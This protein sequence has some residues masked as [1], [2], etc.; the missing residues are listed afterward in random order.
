MIK[1]TFEL[2]REPFDRAN[3]NRDLAIDRDSS[4]AAVKARFQ[5]LA[6]IIVSIVSVP[7]LFLAGLF[8]LL[9]GDCKPLNI[10]IAILTQLFIII[11][12]SLL[13][14]IFPMSW[15]RNID[16]SLAKCTR[17]RAIENH[18][19]DCLPYLQNRLTRLNAA[20]NATIEI[21]DLQAAIAQKNKNLKAQALTQTLSEIRADI[22]AA[23]RGSIAQSDLYEMFKKKEEHLAIESRKTVA[24][25]TQAFLAAHNGSISSQN[26]PI[27]TLDKLNQALTDRTINTNGLIFQNFIDT[28]VIKRGNGPETAQTLQGLLATAQLLLAEP[29]AGKHPA[30]IAAA[31]PLNAADIQEAATPLGQLVLTATIVKKHTSQQL[32]ALLPPAD[33]ATAIVQKQGEISQ[34]A[35]CET[36]EKIANLKATHRNNP[37]LLDLYNSAYNEKF[38]YLGGLAQQKSFE[39]LRAELAIA[40]TPVQESDLTEAIVEKYLLNNSYYELKRLREQAPAPVDPILL[41]ALTRRNGQIDADVRALTLAQ[42]EQNL[43]NTAPVAPAPASIEHK[44]NMEKVRRKYRLEQTKAQLA[45]IVAAAGPQPLIDAAND[46]IQEKDR[47]IAALTNANSLAALTGNHNAQRDPVKKEI[48][49]LARDQKQATIDQLINTKTYLQLHDQHKRAPN[50]TIQKSDLDE[51]RRAKE[52]AL[53]QLL[54]NNTPEQLEALHAAV[55]DDQTVKKEDLAYAIR[56]KAQRLAAA[57]AAAAPAPAPAPALAPVPQPS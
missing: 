40:R 27:D 31:A 26:E 51:A 41:A 22:I 48:L 4:L 42:L 46:A 20:R 47:E 3:V 30:I 17:T 28:L 25:L 33:P 57:A 45:A 35:A 56:Q 32:A 1:D 13:G 49:A 10:P 15:S 6:Q 19:T 5:Y 29:D 53:N 44:D 37:V 39:E 2:F 18:T 7:F 21:E 9:K 52:T 23:P 16:N 38:D 14:A 8:D 12:I 50:N 24:Q 54:Q 36:W 55:P 34:L 11:P 43:T